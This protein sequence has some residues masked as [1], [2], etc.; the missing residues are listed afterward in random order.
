MDFFGNRITPNALWGIALA[1]SIGTISLPFLTEAMRLSNKNI[2]NQIEL[3]VPFLDEKPCLQPL[4]ETTQNEQ[5]IPNTITEE[6]VFEETKTYSGNCKYKC[7]ICEDIFYEYIEWK[8]HMRT[9]T[10]KKQFKCTL[11]ANAHNGKRYL[12]RHMKTHGVQTDSCKQKPMTL[13]SSNTLPAG[14]KTQLPNKQ[15]K[16]NLCYKTFQGERSLAMHM[17][18]VHSVDKP[19][20]CYK[21]EKHS[22]QRVS[23]PFT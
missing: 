5:L 16:C 22:Y 20:S 4:N 12:D 6:T 10:G 17:R 8:S 9:H 7:D 21:C 14:V 19:Y 13:N 23:V 15:Y 2:N 11:C 18:K 3:D 1:Y